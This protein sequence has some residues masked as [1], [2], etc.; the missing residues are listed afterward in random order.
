MKGSPSNPFSLL[1]S[2]SSTSSFIKNESTLMS[3]KVQRN[4][5]SCLFQQKTPSP[6]RLRDYGSPLH[7]VKNS[8]HSH[9]GPN[10]KACKFTF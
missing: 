7:K 3:P 1:N 5:N 6:K 8:L 4:V 10:R 2:T 9:L